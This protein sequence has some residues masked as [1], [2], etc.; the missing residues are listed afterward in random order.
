MGI[1]DSQLK[2]VD[3]RKAQ[4][5][6][7]IDQRNRRREIGCASCEGAHEIGSLTAIQTHWY[8][9]PSGC[10]KGA[11]WRGRITICLP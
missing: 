3:H 2:E 4:I 7:E 10:N 8:V 5:L 1:L 9:S 11:Y 6:E